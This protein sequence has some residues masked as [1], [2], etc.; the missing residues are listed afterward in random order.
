M[1]VPTPIPPIPPAFP[2]VA[3]RTPAGSPEAQAEASRISALLRPSAARLDLQTVPT[4]LRTPTI[5]YF[6]PEDA[7]SARALASALSQTGRPWR[8]QIMRAPRNA[9]PGR[10]EVWLSGS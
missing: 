10:L 2:A 8:L 4:G 7:A 5:R 3:I 1:G 9:V 6:R